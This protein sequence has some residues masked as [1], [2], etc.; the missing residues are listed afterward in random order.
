MTLNISFGIIR[1][2]TYSSNFLEADETKYS[3]QYRRT[4]REASFLWSAIIVF[5]E[6][7]HF[8]T[9]LE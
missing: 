5:V 2:S 6:A 8:E 4:Y 9:I 3:M 7:I 1:D